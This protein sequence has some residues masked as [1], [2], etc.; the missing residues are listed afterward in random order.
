MD[1]I[2]FKKLLLS[3]ITI[4]R[5]VYN[6]DSM[7][8][9]KRKYEK[10]SEVKGNISTLGVAIS[11]RY[12]TM[13]EVGDMKYRI[14][15]EPDVDV[16][17]NDKIIAE[18]T[19]FIVTDIREP[20]YQKGKAHHLQ[21]HVYEIQP[22]F[23]FLIEM[24]NISEGI[25][26]LT[27]IPPDELGIGVINHQTDLTSIISIVQLLTGEMINDSKYQAI[28]RLQVKI[29]GNIDNQ[30]FKNAVLK[31]DRLI[32]S[33]VDIETN[34]IGDL[35]RLRGLKSE[36]ETNSFLSAETS[37]NKK[38]QAILTSETSLE[39]FTTL[40]IRLDSE[41]ISD[42]A[43]SVALSL[44][45]NFESII[46]NES[47]TSSTLSL[48]IALLSLIENT[49][50][51]QADLKKYISLSVTKENFSLFQAVS[52]ISKGLESN[53]E[54]DVTLESIIKRNKKMISEVINDTNLESLLIIL[55]QYEG[56]MI[57]ESDIDTEVKRIRNYIAE[58]ENESILSADLFIEE[59]FLLVGLMENN[60]DLESL[61]GLIFEVQTTILNQS[62]NIAIAG[63]Q[64]KIQAILDNESI[65]QAMI[66]LV[67][68]IEGFI[69]EN[70]ENIVFMSVLF[71][72][73]GF[74]LNESE[75]TGQLRLNL[76]LLANVI[77][78]SE[79]QANLVAQR[80]I[81][82]SIYNE[83]E[84]ISRLNLFKDMKV[85]LLNTIA[86]TSFLT[87]DKYIETQLLSN[88]L[89][90]SLLTLFK[91]ISSFIENINTADGNLK[92]LKYISSIKVNQSELESLLKPLIGIQSEIENASD[93]IALLSALYSVT[94]EI[95]SIDDINALIK[96]DRLINSEVEENSLTLADL[97]IVEVFNR[98]F[99]SFRQYPLNQFP[100]DF[101]NMWAGNAIWE[102]RE[103]IG[104][105]GDKVLF[106]DSAGGA[107]RFIRWDKIAD[108]DDMEL[109][110]LVN[111]QG[112]G[113][114][115]FAVVRGSG[116]AGNET[117]YFTWLQSYG[118]YKAFE[119][120]KT[121]NGTP[122]GLAGFYVEPVWEFNE[123][124]YVRLRAD[125]NNIMAKLWHENDAE[126][127]GWQISATDNDIASGGIGVG[128]FTGAGDRMWDIIGVGIDGATA[129]D[130]PVPPP[131]FSD[132]EE[133]E[134][135]FEP[136]DWQQ[137]W[138]TTNSNWQ[139]VQFAG[140][141][142]LEHESF[143]TDRRLLSWNEVDDLVNVDIFAQSR[144]ENETGIQLGLA[145]R[146]SGTAG[147]E[148]SYI[149]Q[150]D[151]F[152]GVKRLVIR[153]YLN[154]SFLN[155]DIENFEWFANTFYNLRFRVNG[156]TLQGKIWE[157]GDSEPVNWTVEATDT[158]ITGGGWIGFSNVTAGLRQHDEIEVIEI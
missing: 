156:S 58:M 35:D 37:I 108:T 48:F 131:H 30:I 18:G 4:L 11:D 49:S 91:K 129:P 113:E 123:W 69:L 154:G 79:K 1:N 116:S 45:I 16:K 13:Q 133:Y 56:L 44:D 148:N 39:S 55:E 120:Y 51:F 127:V 84:K 109:L 66:K 119:L 57:E 135:N 74:L 117:A 98:F 100:F 29:E 6:Y 7:G 83:S 110:M 139:V 145:V 153:R 128:N 96:V 124:F 2:N 107:Y 20:S 43:L 46:E 115:S 126:P 12:N 65:K 125:G 68:T 50:S 94:S 23:V 8:G 60:A 149:L 81:E 89:M 155:L 47:D 143:A 141:N 71:N 130:V 38:I 158:E 67:R 59:V 101:T 14:F 9:T 138:V 15:F 42:S 122:T 88:S 103:E 54:N 99:N 114:S 85:T 76:G 3:D 144:T 10:I 25:A 93:K 150:A 142:V 121:V 78:A 80:G 105:Q 31:V 40:N 62:D 140:R 27:I 97:T 95:E 90:L 73:Q 87:L 82:T 17:R 104:R 146:A 5:P 106:N 112:D 34:I 53:I 33:N 92:I 52:A 151:I 75:K 19:T 61:L 36:V 111:S 64:R 152:G 32:M 102:V 28:I 86:K 70:S 63:R 21:V 22:D 41:S 72:L 147:N 24:V 157:V 136:A 26:D 134:L 132:F 77:N 118:D 137:R